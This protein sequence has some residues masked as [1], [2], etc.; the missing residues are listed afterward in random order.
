MFFYNLLGFQNTIER[1]F[2]LY[3]ILQVKVNGVEY[4]PAVGSPKKKQAR[5]EAAEVCLKALGVLP[6]KSVIIS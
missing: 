1:K 6:S 3:Q 5:A 2:V 4:K